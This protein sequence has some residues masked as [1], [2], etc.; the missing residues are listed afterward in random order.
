MVPRSRFP[1]TR[2]GWENPKP[3]SQE[4]PRHPAL[5]TTSTSQSA[6]RLERQPTPQTT[7]NPT[8]AATPGTKSGGNGSAETPDT[9][10]ESKPASTPSLQEMGLKISRF[11]E[12][13]ETRARRE[14]QTLASASA[15]PAA[16]ELLSYPE[17]P[18]QSASSTTTVPLQP[19]TNIHHSLPPQIQYPHVHPFPHQHPHSR[20][21]DCRP[22]KTWSLQHPEWAPRQ[23]KSPR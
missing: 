20:S 18:L 21:L 4:T 22:L 14:A 17:V 16:P 12:D 2:R 9:P 5:T 10:T 8:R 15:K 23:A 3:R 7:P 13:Q 1:S 19:N 6:P 11:H